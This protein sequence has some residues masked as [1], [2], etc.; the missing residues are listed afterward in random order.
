MKIYFCDGCNESIPLADIQA[1]QVTTI[2]GKL[3]CR[4]CIPL[5]SGAS[6]SAAPPAESRGTHPLVVLALLGL[7]AYVAWRELPRLSGVAPG[8][9][10]ESASEE[11][12][13]ADHRLVQALQADVNRLRSD[14]DELQ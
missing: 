7:L 6:T 4:N 8:G 2:K 10:P 3:F 1:G 13:G 11:D 12:E 5:G 14:R 9:G